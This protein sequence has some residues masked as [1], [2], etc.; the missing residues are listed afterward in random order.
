MIHDIYRK[1]SYKTKEHCWLLL[2]KCPVDQVPKSSDRSKGSGGVTGEVSQA[3]HF[4]HSEC[5]ILLRRMHQL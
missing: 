2:C 5:L 3:D 4:F 1:L